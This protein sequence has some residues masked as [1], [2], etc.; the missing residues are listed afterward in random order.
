M[1]QHVWDRC[2]ESGEF[3]QIIVATD[4]E[5]IVSAVR[6]FGGHA[7]L[8]SPRCPSGMDRVAEVAHA[9]A[10]AE[11]FINMQGDEPAVH[12]QALTQLVGAFADASVQI[13]TL[14]RPLADPERTNANVV[15]VVQNH[16][17]DALYFSRADIPFQRDHNAK[18]PR[19]AHIG[20]YGYRR[21]TL[22]QLAALPSS[23]LER[24]EGLEQ[25]RA[26]EHGLRIRCVVTG[27]RSQA[28]DSPED[29]AKVE[30][31]LANP[32]RP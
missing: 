5:R 2:R 1:I 7:R 4:D 11:V 19:F 15:K 29:V 18:T 27:Y 8:T 30:Q 14:I 9:V 26:L 23:D 22:L 28:V 3:V 16:R 6:S 32:Y 13:A 12:P 21:P 17:G 31:L 20:L 10:D 25:L 24:S